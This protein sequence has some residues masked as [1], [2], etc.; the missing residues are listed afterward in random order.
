MER[1]SLDDRGYL[2]WVQANSHGFVL[3]AGSITAHI[4]RLH[5]AECGT[6]KGTP[7]HA[8]GEHYPETPWTGRYWKVCSLDKDELLSWA[9]Q[10][11]KGKDPSL[12]RV[13]SP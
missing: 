7:P 11:H 1:F 6:I 9:R 8:R 12:C 2:Q 3:N 4:T 5:R 10:N 13:C